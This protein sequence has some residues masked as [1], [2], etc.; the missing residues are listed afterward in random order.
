MIKH[1]LDVIWNAV[2]HLN[3]DQPVVVALDQPLYAIAKKIQCQWPEEY[4]IHRFVILMGGLHV[5]MPLL[6]SLGDWLDASGWI[7]ALVNSSVATAGVA[8]SFVYGNKVSRTRYAHQVTVVALD[9]L[10][11]R[12]HTRV[13]PSESWKAWC[14]RNG[15]GGTT[16]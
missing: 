7:N 16:I 12:V 8:Q 13:A 2:N 1:A 9:I 11:R 4:G 3:E 6:S 10:L 15:S 14:E 5:E